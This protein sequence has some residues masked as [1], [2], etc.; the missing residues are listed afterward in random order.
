MKVSRNSNNGFIQR[1]EIEK[2]G[3]LKHIHTLL[4][5]SLLIIKNIDLYNSHVLVHCS[6]GWDR[7]AQ[8]VAISEVCLDPY[9]RT[10]EGFEVL[11]E[12]E[13]ISFGHKFSHRCG[14]LA[15]DSANLNEVISNTASKIFNNKSSSLTNKESATS[16]AISSTINAVSNITLAASKFLKFGAANINNITNQ[17]DQVPQASSMDSV[18]KNS[19]LPR[20]TSPIFT[21][22]LDCIYQLWVQNPTQFEFND[23]FLVQLNTHVYSSQF[24]TFLFNSEYERR[25]FRH[26][27][28]DLSQCTYSVWDWFN[29][30]KK[31]YI[32]PRYVPPTK[33]SPNI[34]TESQQIIN[35]FEDS[36]NNDNHNSLLSNSQA[37]FKVIYPKTNERVI[38][39]WSNL[40]NRTD[41]EMN[42]LEQ[43]HSSSNKI[44]NNNNN[45]NNNY[46]NDINSNS[47]D[48]HHSEFN[49]DNRN[50][51]TSISTPLDYNSLAATITDTTNIE[52]PPIGRDS[53]HYSSSSI[54]NSNRQSIQSINSKSSHDS[55]YSSLK[56]KIENSED[57]DVLF[58]SPFQSL[59]SQSKLSNSNSSSNTSLPPN[60]INAEIISSHTS[61][62]NLN[63]S[64][65]INK[66][67]N[68]NTNL[69]VST[70]TTI[71]ANENNASS[72]KHNPE[73]Y[74]KPNYSQINDSS[75]SS[76]PQMA[77]A[78]STFV[79]PLE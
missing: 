41:D 39:Y 55:V 37:Q 71:V 9:Y 66:E 49:N 5:G 78:E 68:N 64:S 73:Y 36:L 69:V 50:S 16:A 65:S 35:E 70:D 21:Q 62:S 48:H 15:K 74:T 23:D 51:T 54:D 4:E 29:S 19:T 56:E 43:T 40:Y 17:K 47:F 14:L 59:K 28:K 53:F 32:N 34:I 72:P 6:D 7:T 61:N 2:T 44:V 13:W 31:S 42:G 38:K 75:I 33:D 52:V 25:V 58:G 8:L 76:M 67:M 11:V 79:H 22:F 60:H 77:T 20:E 3:W 26:E 63:L 10:I 46:N 18:S 45:N 24:G 30:N 1:S 12:K 27:G 57:Y